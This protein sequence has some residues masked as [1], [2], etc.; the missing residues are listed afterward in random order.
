VEHEGA[1]SFHF[2]EFNPERIFDPHGKSTE[3]QW[4]EKRRQETALQLLNLPTPL[5]HEREDLP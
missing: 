4:F 3:A 1:E 2:G 5:P